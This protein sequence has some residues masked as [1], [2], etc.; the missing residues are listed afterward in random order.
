MAFD[1]ESRLVL[2]VVPGRPK[3]LNGGVHLVLPAA[4][5]FLSFE[6]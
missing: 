6:P 2:A 1:P 3:P 5:L 4:F